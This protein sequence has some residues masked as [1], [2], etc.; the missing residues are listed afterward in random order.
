MA[1]CYDSFEKLKE[2]VSETYSSIAQLLEKFGWE[3]FSEDGQIKIEA[4]KILDDCFRISDDLEELVKYVSDEIVK[5]KKE[6]QETET[7]KAED[8]KKAIIKH[9]Y[10]Y[11]RFNVHVDYWNDYPTFNRGC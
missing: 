8:E 5:L 2:S 4:Y 9:L 11:I 10:R 3:F 6:A 1:R 7:L